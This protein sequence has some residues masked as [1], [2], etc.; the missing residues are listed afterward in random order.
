MDSANDELR[1]KAERQA[2][3]TKIQSTAADICKSIMIG[4]KKGVKQNGIDAVLVA[5]IHD[6]ILSIVKKEDIHRYAKLVTSVSKKPHMFDKITDII[7]IDM[8]IKYG[9]R[10]G[11]MVKY[12]EFDQNTSDELVIRMLKGKNMIES[13]KD[14]DIK[15][16]LKKKFISMTFAY[17]E[18]LG[19]N[20]DTK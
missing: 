13:C 5:Q 15:E 17:L 11:S 7:P 4:I 12:N 20:N 1:N 3:N 2:I 16:R 9:E 6:D 19:E 10:W 8:D 14:P 18:K